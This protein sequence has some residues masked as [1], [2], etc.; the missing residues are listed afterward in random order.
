MITVWKADIYDLAG[1]SAGTINVPEG[2]DLLFIGNQGNS[3]SLW[4]R[5]ENTAP[6][7]PRTIAVVGTGQQVP[8][9]PNQYIGTAVMTG[10]TEVWHVFEVLY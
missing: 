5:C 6:L 2:A 9:Q 3:M 4:Y 1:K 7:K 8:R 10:S